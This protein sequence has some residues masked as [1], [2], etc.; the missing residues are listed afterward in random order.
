MTARTANTRRRGSTLLECIVVIVVLAIAV[1]PTLSWMGQAGDE[2]ADQ[3]NSIRAIT[4]A[5][6]VI[7]NIMADSMSTSAGLGFTALA[8][9]AVYL[10][11]PTTGLR[12]RLAD[13]TATYESL[14]F[15]YA[16]TISGLVD[17]DGVVNA[18]TTLNLFRDVRVTVSFPLSDGTT[19]AMDVETVLAD[20]S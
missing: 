3:V 7:E 11:T 20:L 2:R 1:P 14:G 12:A 8:D 6:G 17:A 10:D 18:D 5:Q 4:L 9:P 15:S 13:I 16:V 19:A